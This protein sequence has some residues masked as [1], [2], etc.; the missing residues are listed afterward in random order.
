MFVNAAVLMNDDGNDERAR[1]S[2][3]NG[4][5]S[6]VCTRLSA[7]AKQS[8]RGRWNKRGGGGGGGDDDDDDDDD[9][10]EEEEAT[11][12]RA[13]II[14]ARAHIA[15]NNRV[16]SIAMADDARRPKTRPKRGRALSD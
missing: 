9:E 1:E 12:R 5:K 10:E 16:T 2:T 8:M 13:F 11:T 3:I 4:I 6:F 15:N 14:G 7:R